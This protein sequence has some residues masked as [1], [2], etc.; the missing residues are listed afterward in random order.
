[1][2]DNCV[3]F[4]VA[5]LLHNLGFEKGSRYGY[6]RNGKLEEPYYGTFYKN[7]DTTNSV[8]YEAPDIISA[9]DWLEENKFLKITINT[10]T[11]K[12]S[13][14]NSSTSLSV[15]VENKKFSEYIHEILDLYE[16]NF[17]LFEKE[18]TPFNE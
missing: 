12:F 15:S 14:S 10:D 16:K 7:S 6:L 18:Y 9:L 1:M 2:K 5:K 17:Q 8:C 4:N 13:I 3:S 11:N